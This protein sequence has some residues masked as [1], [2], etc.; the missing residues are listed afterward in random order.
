MQVLEAQ[1]AE[2]TISSLNEVVKLS[3]NETGSPHIAVLKQADYRL[4]P[5]IHKGPLT[6]DLL[7]TF[8]Q[9]AKTTGDDTLTAVGLY[10]EEEQHC[11]QVPLT[12]DGIQELRTTSCSVVNSIFYGG[13]SKP[14]W[15]IIF[16]SQ[17]Y[18]AYGPEAF[19]QALVGDI[20]SAYAAIETKLNELYTQTQDDIPGYIAAEINRM[21][22]YLD[23]AYTKLTQDYQN[24]TPGEFVQ[25]L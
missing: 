4:A 8:Y 19:V 9:A 3:P 24:A 5:V 25:I 23:G 11:Y 12:S 7:E 10:D 18:I 20:D 15:M 14:N 13:N 16:H 22:E 2:S 1:T 21:G 6:A 17:L